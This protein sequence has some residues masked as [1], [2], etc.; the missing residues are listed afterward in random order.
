[1]I[2]FHIH[3]D[4]SYDSR[5]S[6]EDIVE[7]ALDKGIEA[8]CFTTHIDLNPKRRAIDP[9]IRV[10]G[11]LVPLGNDSVEAFISRIHRAADE[12]ADRLAIFVGF[13]FSYGRHF[14]DEIARFIEKFRPDFYLGAIHCLENIGISGRH[15]AP[16]YFR[17][18]GIEKAVDDYFSAMNDLVK[19]RLFTTVAHIDGLKKYG[20]R[21][22]GDELYRLMELRFGAI[23][24]LMSDSGV[25]IEVNTSSLRSGF[26]EMFPSKRLLEMAR[27]AG[28]TV[29]SVGSDA[30]FAT[31]VGFGIESAY[32]LIERVGIG[33]AGPL[34][35]FGSRK[36]SSRSS[37]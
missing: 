24:D 35:E 25:G 12:N 4:F 27:D 7:A 28:V 29:N 2:D 17:S 19:S 9:F 1:M 21:F 16:G 36:T 33:I 14:E 34:A 20:H 6:T 23:F 13:E 18:V 8:I 22:Y 31:D 32:R 11:K 10:D 3:P 5:A 30:H 37:N 15:E 26:T